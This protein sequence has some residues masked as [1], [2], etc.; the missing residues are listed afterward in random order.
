L[1]YRGSQKNNHEN[2]VFAIVTN[3]I[4]NKSECFMLAKNLSTV[5]A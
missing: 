4:E 1:Y 5:S 3:T 2:P